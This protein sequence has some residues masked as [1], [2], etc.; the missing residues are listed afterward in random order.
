MYCRLSIVQNQGTQSYMAQPHRTESALV[1]VTRVDNSRLSHVVLNN[2]LIL[3]YALYMKPNSRARSVRVKRVTAQC[4][5]IL[6][7]LAWAAHVRD[8]LSATHRPK[9]SIKSLLRLQHLRVLH[10]ILMWRARHVR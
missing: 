8:V 9:Q 5:W 4:K 6:A 2:E 7:V 3:V 1:R 10:V